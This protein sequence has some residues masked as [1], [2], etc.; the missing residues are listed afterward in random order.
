MLWQIENNGSWQW[1][2]SDSADMLYLKLS[3][4]NEQENA[5][6]KSWRPASFESV[7]ACVSVGG[8]FDDALCEMTHYRRL[9]FENNRPNSALPV[10]FNDYMHCLWADPTEEK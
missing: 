6:Y 5:W 4:P 1:E 2:I 10:I 9:I 8:C 3:G 7:K